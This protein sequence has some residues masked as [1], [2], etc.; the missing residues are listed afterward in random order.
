MANVIERKKQADQDLVGSF[1]RFGPYGVAYEI[2]KVDDDRLA[3]VRVIESGETLEY[4][5]RKILADPAA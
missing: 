5:I 1:K 3:T 2:I 4:P